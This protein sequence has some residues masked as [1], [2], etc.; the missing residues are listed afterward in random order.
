MLGSRI[1]VADED[2][3]FRKNLKDMLQKGGYQVTQDVGDGQSALRA[4]RSLEPD[5]VILN[6]KLPVTDGIEVAKIVEES[7]LA[8]VI[9]I[10][11]HNRQDILQQAKKTAAMAFLTKPVNEMNL[12]AA[13][14]LAL[15]NYERVTSL[16]REVTELKSILNTRK[17]VEKAKGLLMQQ[18]KIS[19]DQAFK[20]IQ[21]QSMKTRMSMKSVAEAI[22]VAHEIEKE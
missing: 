9:L 5:L 4:I 8:P 14:E 3:I 6:A 21:Q 11:N 16:Q 12:F 13:I 20:K 22:I 17:V 2:S 19:E 1:V 18:L 10:A 15:T 7:Q